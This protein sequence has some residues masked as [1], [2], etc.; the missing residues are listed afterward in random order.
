MIIKNRLTFCGLFFTTIL[1]GLS[2]CAK[3]DQ[4]LTDGVDGEQIIVNAYNSSSIT[5]SR[6]DYTDTPNNGITVDWSSGDTFSMYR[7]SGTQTPATFTLTDGVGTQSGTFEGTLSSANTS[8]SLYAIYP[9]NTSNTTPTSITNSIASQ[10]GGTLNSLSAYDYMT[11]STTYTEGDTPSFTFTHRMA[12]IRF[13]ISLPNSSVTGSTLALSANSG[14]YT[15]GT[16]DLTSGSLTT[17]SNG[18]ITVS[19]GTTT[20]SVYTVYAV[21]YPG[22][23]NTLNVSVQ[24]SDGNTYTKTYSTNSITVEAAKR[25]T[26]ALTMTSNDLAATT[27]LDNL[28]IDFDSSDASSYSYITETVD[29][30]DDDFIENSSFTNE[31]YIAY[32]GTSATVT[33]KVGGSAVSSISGVSIGQSGADIT[34]SSSVLVNYILSGSTTSGSFNISSDNSK[35]CAITLNG[36]TMVNAD[37]PCIY[38]QSKRAYI[39]AASGTTNTL[40]D[41]TSNTL[42]ACVYSTDQMIFSGSGSLTVYGLYKHGICSNDYLRFRDGCNVT[43]ASA[44]TDGIHANDYIYIGGGTLNV[45]STKDG[46]EAEAGYITVNGGSTTVTSGGDALKTSSETTTDTRDITIGG[47]YLKLTT[48]GETSHGIASNGN[49]TMTGGIIQAGVSGNGSKG[50][51]TDG[52]FTISSG[53]ITVINSAAAFYDTDESDITSPAGIKA[54]ILNITGG[55]VQCKSTGK[56]GKGISSDGDLTISGGVV[57]IIT[58]GSTYTYSSSLDAKAKGIK[59]DANIYI[60]GGAITIKTATDGAE[61]IESEYNMTISGG[62][63]AISAYDDAINVST[64]GYTLTIAGGKIY[65]YSSNN[66]GLDSNGYIKITGGIVI[67]DGSTSPEEG[68]DVDSGAITISGGIVIGIGGEM[69]SSTALPGGTQASVC[70]SG[71]SVTSGQYVNI[72][73]SSGTIMTY[74]AK[75]TVSSGRFMFSSSALLSGTSYTLYKGSSFS[76]SSGFYG[77]YSDGTFNTSGAT[78]VG[79]F[80]GGT[81]CVKIGSSSPGGGGR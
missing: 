38:I 64:N 63:I 43:V 65:A 79:T 72:S 68:F 6:L 28:S 80:S 35:K 54:N 34:A 66:D 73:S 40:K 33:Y 55:T 44:V 41:G 5:T 74:K 37:A 27:D 21:V 75:R 13:D 29:S 10:S 17:S 23:I 11:A 32:S 81:V 2:S 42:K 52:T 58:T 8:T 4:Y 25:Y 30:S 60:K 15:S 67:G 69:N 48:T 61:G 24:T 53:K 62:E 14:L 16:F 19:G 77:Y 3:D 1:L 39:V 7:G 70:C 51:K 9:S 59:S 56:G 46:I 45:T 47:G 22:T 78:T 12:V 26:A 49:I 31:V 57:K 36:V 50:L 18:T 76:G 20:S 71:F